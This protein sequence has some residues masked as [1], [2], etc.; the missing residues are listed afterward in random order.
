MQNATSRECNR[1]QTNASVVHRSARR[2]ILRREK[3]C[4]ASRTVDETVT[5]GRKIIRPTPSHAASQQTRP[6]NQ[7]TLLSDWFFGHFQKFRDETQSARSHMYIGIRDG[8]L[9]GRW[10]L[11]ACVHLSHS[12][13]LTSPGWGPQSPRFGLFRA[14]CSR[15]RHCFWGS[16]LG[17]EGPLLG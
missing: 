7:R 9:T 3:I 6:T 15:A 11:C 14:R 10:P 13:R 16:N 17:H 5:V 12:S 2:S 8:Y 1:M 4:L